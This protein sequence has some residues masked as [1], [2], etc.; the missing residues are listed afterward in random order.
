MYKY[1]STRNRNVFIGGGMG[2]T[3]RENYENEICIRAYD[4]LTEVISS[5]YCIVHLSNNLKA[6]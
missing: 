1:S 4:K 6:I 3:N 2:I 5:Q